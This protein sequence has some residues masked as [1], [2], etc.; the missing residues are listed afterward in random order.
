MLVPLRHGSSSSGVSVSGVSGSSRSGEH[1]F[2]EGDGAP[3]LEHSAA[4]LGD[5]TAQMEHSAACASLA[6]GGA[7]Q[8]ATKADGSNCAEASSA[9]LAKLGDVGLARALDQASLSLGEAGNCA[10]LCCAVLA[11]TSACMS[12]AAIRFFASLFRLA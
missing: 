2:P 8:L 1:G 6:D 7:G 10:V 9:P 4:P 3:Q 11:C 5:G 12:F